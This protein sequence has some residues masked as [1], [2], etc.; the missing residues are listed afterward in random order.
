MTEISYIDALLALIGVI[1]G[2]ALHEARDI[3]KNTNR[4]NTIRKALYNEL[5]NIL[6]I[7]QK[8]EKS[9]KHLVISTD[10]FPF[11][12][13][14]Y[15]SVKLE[16]ASFL[17]PKELWHI[18]RTYTQ[19]NKLN[20]MQSSANPEGYFP[21]AKLFYDAESISLTINL[22]TKARQIVN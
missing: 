8:G 17:K 19:V 21:S 3:I 15:E 10:K 6:E 14:T 20:Q 18:Q 12:V 7:L 1:V 16:L 22:I 2:F 5:T 9:D 11:I 13:E 4:K